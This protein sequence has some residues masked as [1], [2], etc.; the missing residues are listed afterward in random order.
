MKKPA[1]A[2]LLLS[3][4]LLLTGCKETATSFLDWITGESD[5]TLR[6][7]LLDNDDPTAPYPYKTVS[8]DY[9]AGR[10]AQ[11]NYDWT[12]AYDFMSEI[13]PA[14]PQ[15]LDLKKR[16]MVLAMGAGHAD[17]A[18]TL[19][20]EILKAG[21]TGSL[22]RLFLMLETFKAGKYSDV[23]KQ[24]DTVPKDGISEFIN[25]LIRSWA[26]AGLGQT[27]TEDL[28]GNVVHLY[29]AVLIADYLNDTPALKKLA[30]RNY[31][32][33]S[34]APRSLERVADIFARHKLTPQAQTLYTYIRN[35][36]PDSA[37]EI[38]PKVAALEKG[39]LPTADEGD[40]IQSPVDGLS[41]ALF[42]MASVL[43]TEYQDSARLFSQMS[44]YLDQQNNDARVLLGHM[45]A[46]YNRYDE[47]IDYYQQIDAGDDKDL[48]I[49]LQRQ[50]AELLEE[51]DKTDQAAKVLRKLVAD[52]KDVD[53]QIQLGDLERRHEDYPAAL[54][55][56]NKA[57][58]ML[59]NN[60]PQ[61]YWHLLYA[62]G[63]TNERLKNWSAA[64]TDL[65]AA[66][67]Y[68]PDHP[69]VLN[70]LGYS[71]ADQGIN[72]DKAAEMIGRA[73]RLR[74]DDG[75]IV[76]SLGWVYFRMQKYKDAASTLES[77]VELLPYDPTINDHLGDAY[78][79]VGRKT[80]A[81]FQWRRAASF[82]KDQT[83]IDAIDAK[84]KNGMPDTAALEAVRPAEKQARVGGDD[85][86]TDSKR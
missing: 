48:Q 6:E 39:T 78:W 56:Y 10:F 42:D 68:E 19:A 2:L 84:I 58:D 36:D 47:A 21:D 32:Q 18:F 63:M 60:V 70:Y 28:G 54:K 12:Q 5:G 61:E 41:R 69:Y 76:D 55:E 53:T 81:R 44:L 57:A 46:R 13:I 74:P 11:S 38:T 35:T 64:E 51:D 26:K 71:W 40:I 82:S 73:V 14:D 27:D 24:I 8:G 17:Q 30:E 25:P 72:L 7:S 50:I 85:P 20:R 83:E 86:A 37:A 65:K 1:S 52:T 9:L 29:H 31:T 23:L 16:T 79:R 75:Y 62:R 66:L 43:Y 67:A 49:K 45:A 15:N 22:P 33:F 80:E 59:G 77:A 3:T 34:L 4:A